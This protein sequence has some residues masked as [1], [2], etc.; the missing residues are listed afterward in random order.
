[1]AKGLAR[2]GPPAPED[3]KGLQGGGE[4]TTQHRD[5]KGTG[6]GKERTKMGSVGA[7]EAAVKGRCLGYGGKAVYQGQEEKMAAGKK[8][9]SVKPGSARRVKISQRK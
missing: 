4:S 6:A 3:S 9:G 1:M 2:A 8:Q 5:H 7:N